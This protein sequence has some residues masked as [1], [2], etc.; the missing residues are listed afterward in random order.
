MKSQ[1]LDVSVTPDAQVGGP[2][3]TFMASFLSLLSLWSLRVTPCA[4]L[5]KWRGWFPRGPDAMFQSLEAGQDTVCSGDTA[6]NK[7]Q[8]NRKPRPGRTL[9]AQ[10]RG[11]AQP[12][13]KRG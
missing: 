3:E 8:H 7:G 1:G 5:M 13:W 6:V 4:R 10:D 11:K 9:R 12:G 2:E